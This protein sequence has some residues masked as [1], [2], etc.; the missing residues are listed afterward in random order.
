MTTMKDKVEKITDWLEKCEEQHKNYEC[1]FPPSGELPSRLIKL[2]PKTGKAT[3]IDIPSVPP[4]Y[5]ALS[6]V[7]G[8]PEY[9]LTTTP[10]NK[11]DMY[12]NIPRDKLPKTLNDVFELVVKLKVYYLWVDALCIIQGDAKD[13]DTE[14]RK[15][16]AIYSNAYLVISAMASKGVTDGL[17]LGTSA[18]WYKE[19]DEFHRIMRTC[20]TMSKRDWGRIVDD[21]PL[22]CRG[23]AF[24]ERLLARRVVHFTAFELVWECKEDRWCGCG[25]AL[26]DNTPSGK[27]NN[28]SSAFKSCISNPA[29]EKIR[30]MWRECVTS[31]SKRNLTVPTDRLTAISGVARL[32]R[33]PDHDKFLEGLW[34]DTLPSDLLWYCEQSSELSRKRPL[35]PSWSWISVDCGIEWPKRDRRQDE[36]A[37]HYIS[38]ATYFEHGLNPVPCSPVADGE[39]ALR[40]RTRDVYFRK[41]RGQ[42]YG[43]ISKTKSKTAHTSMDHTLPFYP[44]I[45]LSEGKY[46]FLE[47][48]TPE[49]QNKTWHIGL[50]VRPCKGTEGK[51]ER[52]GLAGDVL[53]DPAKYSS[54]WFEDGTERDIVLGVSTH[55]ASIGHTIFQQC[56]SAWRWFV[57]LMKRILNRV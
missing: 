57:A 51:Y 9:N 7:W 32:L 14:S 39:L 47:I 26:N 13:W 29:D 15:M 42:N 50:I 44:D 24:Q 38:S 5:I 10:N 52:V 20:R 46:L 3:L 36:E 19:R 30:P 25:G 54:C 53:C 35:T 11:A 12:K 8:D 48:F 28:M 16:G 6:Y 27:I 22:L 2:D 41:Q 56:I 40:T 23:W 1:N 43:H 21:F 37:L 34:K 55:T 45:L 18:Y 49:H 17:F 31:F 33:E 4:S